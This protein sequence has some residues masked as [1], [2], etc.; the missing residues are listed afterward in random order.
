MELSPR[1]IV[2]RRRR[3]RMESRLVPTPPDGLQ[4]TIHSASYT[5]WIHRLS[6]L[7]S[8]EKNAAANPISFAL[9]QMKQK[10]QTQQ[11]RNKPNETIHQ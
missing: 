11:S 1:R 3:R 9:H 4:N 6:C 8:Y 7:Q 2:T 5:I 10:N